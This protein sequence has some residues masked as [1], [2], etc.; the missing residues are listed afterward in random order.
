MMN[1]DNIQN[2]LRT[3]IAELEKQSANI[4]KH[5]ESLKNISKDEAKMIN[6]GMIKISELDKELKKELKGFEKYKNYK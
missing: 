2:L 6:E 1:L 3:S 4:P 5:L